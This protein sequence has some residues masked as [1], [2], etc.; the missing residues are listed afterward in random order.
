MNLALNARDAMPNGGR[1]TLE[2]EQVVINGDY[3]RLHPW[4]RAGRYVLLSVADTGTGMPPE[5]LERV[6]EPF[7]TTKAAGSGTGLGLAVTWGIV[8]QHG[9]MIHG[10][11]ELGVGTAFK[12]YLPVAEAAASNIGTKIA[13]LAPGGTERI[14]VADDQPHVLSILTRVLTNAGYTVTPVANGADAIE[15]ARREQHDLYILDVV[16]PIL[17]GRDTS[18]HVR[19]LYPDARILFTSGYGSD[20]LPGEFLRDTGIEVVAK[21]FDPDTMLR[22]VR[23]SLDRKR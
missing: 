23:E 10:Y 5:V 7:F 3:K 11:S 9:G 16:M 12:V 8:Q 2:T 20:A 18:E 4:A 21:P 19:S 6:F 22:T 1:L 13:R 15:A 14:L 17:S